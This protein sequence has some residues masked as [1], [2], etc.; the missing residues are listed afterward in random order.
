MAAVYAGGVEQAYTLFSIFQ[1]RG[2]TVLL[3]PLVQAMVQVW[4]EEE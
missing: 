4:N 1:P 2:Y 3:V